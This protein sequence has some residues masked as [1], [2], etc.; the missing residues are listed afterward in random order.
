MTPS[1][2][3]LLLGAVQV[4]VAQLAPLH[5]PENADSAVPNEYIVGLADNCTI[6]AHWDS[7]QLSAGAN[8][9]MLTRFNFIN[10]YHALMDEDTLHK[11]VRADPA[12]KY[13]EHN[14]FLPHNSWPTQD[15]RTNFTDP[16]LREEMREDVTN[17]SEP[18][19][20][21]QQGYDE[22]VNWAVRMVNAGTK[23]DLSLWRGPA[24]CLIPISCWM[25]FPSLSP[26]QR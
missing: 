3:W 24:V 14:V 2:L 26:L 15:S 7:I 19:R 21:W 18:L 5:P 22:N 13:V 4:A 17:E 10:A 9:S 23:L 6:D 16:S 11:L 12:V 1:V 20:R 25:L 8:V